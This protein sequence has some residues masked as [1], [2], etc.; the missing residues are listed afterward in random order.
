M[1]TSYEMRRA[2]LDG[3]EKELRGQMAREH[4]SPFIGHHDLP[5]SMRQAAE[6]ALVTEIG[7]SI[8]EFLEYVAKRYP[9]LAAWTVATTIAEQY[10]PGMDYASY[11]PIA[12]RLGIEEIPAHRREA[13]NSRFRSACAAHGLMLPPKY[14][15]TQ[16]WTGDYL[17]QAGVP[18][19]QLDQLVAA[20]LRVER[21][22][23][24]PFRDDTAEV[25]S[26]EAEALERVP[27]RLQTM[28]KIL[29]E[30]S[31]GYH[32]TVYVRLREGEAP[33]S[34]F[35]RR[36]IDEIKDLS[37]GPGPALQHPA[38]TFSD[39]DL[40]LEHRHGQSLEVEF[41]AHRP[42]H[43]LNPQESRVV[44]LPWPSQVRWRTSTPHD[45][46]RSLSLFHDLYTILLFDGDSGRS[47][48][49]LNP[50]RGDGQRVPAGSIALASTLPFQVNGEAAY[51]IDTDAYVLY[52]ERSTSLRIIQGD[53]EYRAQVDPRLRLE[54]DGCKVARHAEGL[55]LAEPR[56][57]FVRGDVS[58]LASNLEVKLVYCAST[59][60]VPVVMNS[61]D[62]LVAPLN[63]PE[64]GPFGKVRISLHARNQNRALY[65]YTFWYWP[66]LRGLRDGAVFESASIPE[67]LAEEHLEHVNGTDGPLR[68]RQ[69]IPY[70]RAVLA[71]SVERK[72]VRF[73]F[74]PPG[75]SLFVRTSEGKESAISLGKRLIVTPEQSA[76][77]LVVRC[78]DQP[79]DIDFKGSII[80][81]PFDRF[82]LWR[83][84][85]AALSVQG[86]H[87]VIRLR[88][89]RRPRDLVDLVRVG[90]DLRG[91]GASR[92]GYVRVVPR[93]AGLVPTTRTPTPRYGKTWVGARLTG[94]RRLYSALTVIGDCNGYVGY[95][96]GQA[97]RRDLAVEISRDSAAQEMK[98]VPRRKITIRRFNSTRVSFTIH[99]RVTGRFNATRVSL[100]PADP[101]TGVDVSEPGV[102]SVMEAVMK[103]AGIS[104]VIIAFD[105]RPEI[106]E[107]VRAVFAGFSAL[108]KDALTRDAIARGI[109]IDRR[110]G[111]DARC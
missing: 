94:R 41:G 3:A 38:L 33:E 90:P 16:D 65:R 102:R 18:V 109:S 26:W 93:R 88:I 61:K 60:S 91:T 42:P 44:P 55:L 80:R 110:G 20:F 14:P 6:H 9:L 62:E 2:A 22:T 52:P 10:G 40:R 72:I 17:F 32:A 108:L 66:G 95:R 104:D 25:K 68:L 45:G 28:R 53:A 57:V 84:S 87:N 30:D 51:E 36:F 5:A 21:Q 103:A 58:G 19:S 96:S 111:Y 89:A 75:V 77:H 23:G 92:Q 48:G 37:K 97:N 56:C 34:T 49:S 69:D 78:P 1:S 106:V 85:F 13:F 47:N 24:L 100:Q 71:F 98:P 70:L 29:R 81:E 46:W 31:T 73:T 83:K 15:G 50:G 74:P 39:G 79:A 43:Q 86:T 101:G 67:N 54:I 99:R 35:E 8:D 82:G 27:G 107:S 4:G 11:R 105:G 7:G 63:L 76:S 59:S 64:R 12:N